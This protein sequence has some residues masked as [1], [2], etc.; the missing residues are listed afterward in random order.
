MKISKISFLQGQRVIYTLLAA[1]VAASICV[2]LKTPLPWLLGPLLVT[3][4]LSIFGVKTLSWTPLRNSAQWTIGAALGLYFT[5]QVNSVVISLWWAILFSVIWALLLGLIYE[6]WLHWFNAPRLPYLDRTTT[7]FSSLIGAAPEMT[8][9]AERENARTDLVA[10]AHSLRILIV[11]VT[12]PFIVQ[13][14]GW[15]D[16]DSIPDQTQRFDA[17]GFIGLALV[18]SLGVWGVKR[19]GQSNS[20]FLGPLAASIALASCEVTLSHIPTWLTNLSQLVIGVSLGVRFT[21]EFT[22]GAPRWLISVAIGTLTMI[23]L[24]CLASYVLCSSTSL[25]LPT[26]I[27]ATAPGGIAEMAI[28]AK[29]LHL[30]VA[31]VTAIQACRV[32]AILVLADPLYKLLK[33]RLTIYS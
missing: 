8:L 28:T 26:I 31:V 5:P 27:L 20:W 2:T 29:V 12:V 32:I 3:A 19:L 30:G 4:T 15:H 9:L 18:T 21:S 25:P 14:F 23:A 13:W 17:K 24:S 6:F 10:S 22:Q 7:F 16:L 33:H 1:L 11:A